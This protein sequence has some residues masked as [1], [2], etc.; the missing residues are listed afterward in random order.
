M[1]KKYY[2]EFN[3]FYGMFKTYL[4]LF[5]HFYDFKNET[6][7]R[8]K[9]LDKFMWIM[10][11][12]ISVGYKTSIN[13]VVLLYDSDILKLYEGLLEHQEKEFKGIFA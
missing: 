1:K 8:Y 12:M 9:Y 4:D 10:V 5:P 3:Y 7:Q 6:R 11:S 13:S 2:E